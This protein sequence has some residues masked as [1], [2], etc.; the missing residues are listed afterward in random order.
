MDIR[1]VMAIKEQM[2]RFEAETQPHLLPL[3]LSFQEFGGTIYENQDDT[4]SPVSQLL[5]QSGSGNRKSG[6]HS[7]PV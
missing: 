2:E 6:S 7:Q 3:F 5:S 1:K 4:K